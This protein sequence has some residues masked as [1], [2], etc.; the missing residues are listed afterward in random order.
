M[1]YAKAKYKEAGD[2]Q[3]GKQQTQKVDSRVSFLLPDNS[4][5]EE[6]APAPSP[7]IADASQKGKRK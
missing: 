2:L 1:R 7:K 3:K 6:K 4:I 5:D